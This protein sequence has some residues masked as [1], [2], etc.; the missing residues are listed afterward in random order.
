MGRRPR[1]DPNPPRFLP[2]NLDPARWGHTEALSGPPSPYPPPPTPCPFSFLREQ[3]RTLSNHPSPERLPRSSPTAAFSPRPNPVPGLGLIFGA[4]AAVAH[5]GRRT[6]EE[7]RHPPSRPHRGSASNL[8]PPGIPLCRKCSPGGG[9]QISTA[10]GRGAG[11]GPGRTGAKIVP[12]Q[13]TLRARSP[14]FDRW[15]P[16]G[17]AILRV[18]ISEIALSPDLSLSA[19]QSAATRDLPAADGPWVRGQSP[20]ASGDPCPSRPDRN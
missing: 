3:L 13:A 19:A 9:A 16:P 10:S 20:R 12:T 17:T 15:E 8:T 18:P 11:A 2:P 6:H 14:R 5:E 7:P 4:A 1:L